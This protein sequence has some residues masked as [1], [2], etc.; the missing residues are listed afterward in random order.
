M[1]P[2]VTV[3]QI[4][5]LFPNAD[6]ALTERI[7]RAVDLTNRAAVPNQVTAHFSISG[8][9]NLNGFV[10]AGQDIRRHL[11][12]ADAVVVGVCTL[13][14][15]IDRLLEKTQLSDLACAYLLDIAASIAVE[16]VAEE[17]WQTLKAQAESQGKSVTTRYSC[18]YG[19][20]DLSGADKALHIQVN[21][22]GMMYPTKSITFLVGI[23][24]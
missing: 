9:L 21:E 12:G 24:A 22:G 5:R 1:K 11:E 7:E 15:G 18:G 20:F 2:A 4:A 6:E 3:T 19:D 8:E 10:P 16:N 17:M 14:A 23:K 13:G